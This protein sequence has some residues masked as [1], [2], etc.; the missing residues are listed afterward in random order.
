MVV[1]NR[2]TTAKS[3]IANG[4]AIHPNC[5]ILHESD[6]TPAPITPVIICAPAVHIVPFFPIPEY[7]TT[8]NEPKPKLVLAN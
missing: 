2:V 8:K 3:I 7:T 4:P 6:S 5:A 1:A